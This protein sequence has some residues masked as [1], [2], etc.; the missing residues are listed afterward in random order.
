M[1]SNFKIIVHRDN[2]NLYL[3]LLGDFDGFSAHQLV[4]TLKKHCAGAVSIFIHTS[5]LKH[6]YPFAQ[7]TL[8]N[9]LYSLDHE[10]FGSLIF[11]G[12][13]ALK[14]APINSKIL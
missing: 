10:F 3:Q 2:D 12:E 5:G 4:N 6:I 13:C 11:T 1:A 9:N 7:N 14:I 8:Q